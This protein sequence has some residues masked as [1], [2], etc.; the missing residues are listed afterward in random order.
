[1]KIGTILGLILLIGGVISILLYSAFESLQKVNF[2]TIPLLMGIAGAAI[3][4][5]VIMLFIS[6]VFEQKHDMDKR[7]Q[8]IKKEEF[9][10]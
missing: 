4:I 8:E 7:K 1:M 2:A 10:P 5:G 3:V 9:E 6:I